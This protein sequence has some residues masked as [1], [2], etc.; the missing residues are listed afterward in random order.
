MQN[1]KNPAEKLFGAVPKVICT[2]GHDVDIEKATVPVDREDG[3]VRVFCKGCGKYLP[4]TMNGAQEIAKNAG[5]E[6]PSDFFGVYFE[7][8]QCVFCSDE[9]EFKGVVL[10]HI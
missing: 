9:R 3:V 7:S 5:A 10:K 4:I 6:L 1:K 8:D 2:G